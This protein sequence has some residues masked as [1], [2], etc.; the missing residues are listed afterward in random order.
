M[1]LVHRLKILLL[2]FKSKTM[3]KERHVSHQNKER[4]VRRGESDWDMWCQKRRWNGLGLEQDETLDGS[5]VDRWISPRSNDLDIEA[6]A[7]L[8]SGRTKIMRLIFI[9]D[10]CNNTAIQLE[11]LRMTYDV[12]KKGENNQLFR[13]VVQKIDCRLGLNYSMDVSCCAMVDRKAEQRK[14]KLE[15]D[16]NV[17]KTNLIKESI[18]MRYNDFGDF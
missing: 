12:L 6:Y 11:A 16:L 1:P 7:A 8:Y 3:R 2:G 9:A 18:R 15:S 17:Y 13:E 10:H 5:A 4:G 14:E